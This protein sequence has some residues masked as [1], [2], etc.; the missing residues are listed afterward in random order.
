M[1]SRLTR[2]AR[3]LAAVAAFAL[4]GSALAGA[5]GTAPGSSWSG[6]QSSAAAPQGAPP[7]AL[8]AAARRPARRRQRQTEQLLTGD[9][10]DEGQS[11]RAREGTGHGAAR[12]VRRRPRLHPTR[13]TYASP[14]ARRSR[15]SSTRDF[16]VTA[17]NTMRHLVDE[18]GTDRASGPVGPASLRSPGPAR[19]ARLIGEV[20]GLRARRP[21]E[22]GAHR[23]PYVSV[24]NGMPRRVSRRRRWPAPRSAAE[25][26]HL[27]DLGRRSTHSSPGSISPTNG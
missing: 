6:S 1:S 3:L 4:G 9:P 15:Y 24:R 8:P 2:D 23:P 22:R 19:S 20:G 7:A 5:H 14:T 21:P 18:H 11:R 13:L 25:L 17:V 26:E 16:E 27:G 12:R 10:A